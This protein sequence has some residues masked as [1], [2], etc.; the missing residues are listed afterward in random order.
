[1]TTLFN[2]FIQAKESSERIGEQVG[3]KIESSDSVLRLSL[4]D[5]QGQ[6]HPADKL[7]LDFLLKQFM[8]KNHVEKRHNGVNM[9]ALQT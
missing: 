4:S 2:R 9:K 7:T 5:A 3:D 1:M 6:D 8:S